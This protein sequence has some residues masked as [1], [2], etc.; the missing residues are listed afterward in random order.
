MLR[1]LFAEVIG[2]AFL[3]AAGVG[4]VIMAS[5]LGAESG[6]VL[7]AASVSTGG[8]LF[9][10][11]TVLGPVSGAH[12]NPVVSLAFAARGELGAA[13]T[14]AYI[15]AQCIGGVI[16]I[17]AVHAMFDLS[18][19][20][21]STTPRAGVSLMASEAIATFGLLFTIFGAIRARPEAV[22][23]L[24]GVYIMAAYW[25]TSSTSFSNP[26][27]TLAR[28]LT[29]SPAGIAPAD[30]PGWIAGQIAGTL[31]AA[32]VLPRLFSKE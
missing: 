24:V 1:R 6:L 26:A 11:I 3:V 31:L 16:G 10:L 7:L 28:M 21:I 14:A 30:A 32:L 13:A 4:S 22:P 23:A 19:F 8:M 17:A 18:L 15:P 25:F 27:V 12:L 20:Q 5:N 29:D 2:T 9:V